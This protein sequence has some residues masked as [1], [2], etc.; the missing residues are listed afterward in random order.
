MIETFIQIRRHNESGFVLPYVLFVILILAMATTIAAQRLL[1]ANTAMN[2]MQIKM[3]TEK[4]LQS[5][6][7]AASYS[8]LTGNP[9]DKGYDLSPQSP[10]V[11]EFGFLSS[12]GLTALDKNAVQSLSQDIWHANG[13]MRGYSLP[14]GTQTKGSSP[15]LVAVDA[16]VS[17]QDTTGLV[18]LNQTNSRM[19][20]P[21]LQYA[22]APRS[23][24]DRL[25]HSLWDYIDFDSAK[26]V[27][28]A[29]SREYRRQKKTP[30]SNSPIRSYEELGA[31]LY[32]NEMSGKLDMRKLKELTTINSTLGFRET[33]ATQTLKNL[34]NLDTESLHESRRPSFENQLQANI[35]STS[36]AARIRIWAR[37]ADGQ[38]D[39][40]VIEIER[41]FESVDMPY[42]RHWVY[43]T[44]VLESDFEKSITLT[45]SRGGPLELDGLKH[46]VHAASS[47]P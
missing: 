42:R 39:K 12:D 18:S 44:T 22:G 30:P 28:G 45:D 20:K 6:E 4:I 24:T 15:S 5:A 35:N 31:L 33:F 16:V 27:N 10:I 3:R 1:S 34:I 29:E 13:D 32:W 43:E 14:N 21:V 47:A 25:V 26:R 37:R 36:G 19:L 9:G 23:Q 7:A 11:W 46:V 17:L 2:E 41:K 8:L 38:L 40:R